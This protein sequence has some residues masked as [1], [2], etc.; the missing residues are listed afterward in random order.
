MG[1]RSKELFA[2]AQK[3]IPGGVNSSVR[4]FKPVGG[5]PLFMERGEGSRMWDA[6]GAEYIDYVC[7]WGPLILGHA[8]PE[9]VSAIQET[10]TKGT[11]FGTPTELETELA[12]LVVD[13]VP[14]IDRVRMCNSGTEATMSALRLARGYTNR[15]KVVKFQ[16]CY[17]GHVDSLLV[18]AGSGAL[19]L[20]VPTSPGVPNDLA[21]HTH[22]LDYND[23]EGVRALF[24]DVGREVAAVIVEPVAGNMGCIPP[25]PEFL[26]TLREVCDTH[27][28]VL[29][30]DEVM[31][32]F[33]VSLGGAQ[34]HYQV[35]ADLTCLGKV[36]GGGMPVGAFGGRDA[37]M[38]HLSPEGPVYQAGTLAGNPVAMAAGIATLQALSNHLFGELAEKTADLA[39]G[40]ADTGAEFGFPIFENHIGAMFGIFFS[41]R[42][43]R[44]FQDVADADANRFAHFFH[45]MLEQGI[46]LAPSPFEAGFVSRAHSDDDIDRTLEAARR[47]LKGM[48]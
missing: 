47:V 33:R 41:D 27:G 14:S 30:F 31:T 44:T 19:S 21:Q 18:K 25:D 39:T 11:S 2:E 46:Y 5:T 36:I 28:A 38:S 48:G 10:V 6:D 40:L 16:G 29:I 32:G 26:Q 7:S 42:P 24:E 15:D 23:S 35:H 17:H 8:P 34:A 1:K 12:R 37:I 20:G 43:V 4:A 45:G 3:Y 9:V 13:N 22:T